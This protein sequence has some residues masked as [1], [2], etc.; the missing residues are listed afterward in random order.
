MSVNLERL[1]F[2][3]FQLYR[4]GGAVLLRGD[5]VRRTEKAAPDLQIPTHRSPIIT[6]VRRLR[7]AGGARPEPHRRLR[8]HGFCRFRFVVSGHQGLLY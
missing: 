8:C 3:R 1:F 2:R 7:A 6:L 4:L 5:T